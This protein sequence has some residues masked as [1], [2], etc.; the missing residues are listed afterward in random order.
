MKKD[1]KGG[2]R[3]KPTKRL[4]DVLTRE[5]AGKLQ[6]APN[7][8][9]LSGRRNKALIILLMNTGLRLSEALSLKWSDIDDWNTGEFTV[10]EGKGGY[11]RK[12]FLNRKTREALTTYMAS[13]SY[14]L[15]P[16]DW[17]FRT[18]DGDRL[19]CRYVQRMIDRMAK[20]A[21]I[22]KHVYPHLLRHTAG[23]EFY[24]REYDLR[25]T[26]E[27]LGHKSITSTMIYTQ[28]A[29]KD[30]ARKVNSFEL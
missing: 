29:P 19:D 30:L 12:G 8:R 21:A 11:D 10:R 1:A 4:P 14:G 20:R 16:Y 15:A 22:K 3:R 18:R 5:E 13:T 28:I 24:R 25:A 2:K 7:S 17:V 6:E 23:T 27:F 26:Q 9:Y